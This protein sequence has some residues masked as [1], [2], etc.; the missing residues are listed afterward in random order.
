[1]Y[2]IVKKIIGL[3]GT[4]CAGKNHVA[5]ILEQRGLPV[6]D[7]DLLGHLALETEKQVI[8]ARFG[9]DILN[10]EGKLD[11]RALGKKAFG[12][13]QKL[14]ELEAIIHPIVNIMTEQW[15]SGQDGNCV[16]NAALLHKS[17]AFNNLDFVILVNAPIIT[18][19]RRARRRDRLSWASLLVRFTRQKGFGSQYLAGKADIYRIGNPGFYG[20]PGVS[21]P[22]FKRLNSMLESRIDEILTNEGI[23]LPWKRKNYFL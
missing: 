7:I 15:I 14:A 18:R 6:L 11:R 13:P 3:T 21:S 20:K 5:S 16:I 8:A 23:M 17:S 10:P 1:M 12:D 19:I 2:I 9:E 4:Y 22:A